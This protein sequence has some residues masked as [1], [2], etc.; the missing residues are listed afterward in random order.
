MKKKNC[1]VHFSRVV[2]S[3]S[4]CIVFYFLFSNRAYYKLSFR[5]FLSYVFCFFLLLL[6]NFA[7]NTAKCPWDN[8]MQNDE[9]SIHD[10]RSWK[11][12]MHVCVWYVIVFRSSVCV[13]MNIWIHPIWTDGVLCGIYPVRWQ[14]IFIN[15]NMYNFSA[16]MYNLR[17]W[18]ENQFGWQQSSMFSQSAFSKRRKICFSFGNALCDK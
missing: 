10:F 16:L 7:I 15:N 1:L 5:T 6:L 8:E 4:Q 9:I 13:F 3:C 17:W 11:A 12:I 2:V 14:W 18:K